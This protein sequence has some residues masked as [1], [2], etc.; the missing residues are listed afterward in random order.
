MVD[1]GFNQID[2]IIDWKEFNQAIEEIVRQIKEKEI[3]YNFDYILGIPRGGL[4]VA[5]ALSHKLNLEL[6][7]ENVY[8]YVRKLQQK[9]LVVDDITDTGKTLLKFVDKSK[10]ATLFW[11]KKSVVIPDFY[12]KEAKKIEWVKFPWEQ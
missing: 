9:T 2:R 8:D 11:K 10:I 3:Q 6:V 12:Y 7:T 5:V 4:V 1:K